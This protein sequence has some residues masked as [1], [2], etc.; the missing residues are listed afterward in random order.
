MTNNQRVTAAAWRLPAEWEPQEGVQLTWPHAATDWAPMLDEITATY[1]VMAREMARRERLLVVGEKGLPLPS[2][3][4]WARDHGFISLVDDQGHRRLLDFCFN[5]WGEKFTADLDNALNRQLFDAQALAGD[6]VSCLDFVLEGGAIESD[7][8][9]TVFTTSGCLLAPHRNQPL[10]NSMPNASSGLIMAT[11]SVMIP[12]DIS[13]RWCVSVPTTPYYMWA[14]T[15]LMIRSIPN[16]SLWRNNS[17]LSVPS[18]GV[19]TGCSDFP[20]RDR[21]TRR[22]TLWARKGIVCQPPTPIS[23]SSTGQYSAR[24]TTS[25]TSTP[26]RSTSSRRPSPTGRWSPSTAAPSSA[27]TALSIVVPCNFPKYD[28]DWIPAAEHLS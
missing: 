1:E 28:K 18:R 27:S 9:G 3:D 5:G 26:R 16:S 11:S 6:Y 13:T 21:S 4:T 10:S 2:N 25:L 15:I 17:G 14:A 22:T 20:C 24:P 8:R 19:L 12:T 23:S 7:G